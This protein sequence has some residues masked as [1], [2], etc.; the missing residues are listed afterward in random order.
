MA[1]T[2]GVNVIETDG[3]AAPSIQG[4]A[5]SVAAFVIRS[6]RGVPGAVRRISS[7]GQFRDLFGGVM[8]GAFGAFAVQG[9]LDNGGA[10][11]YVTRVVDDTA[12]AASTVT[13]GSELTGTAGYRGVDDPG[14]WGDDVEVAVQD[15][16]VVS[17]AYDLIVRY[18]GTVVETWEKLTLDPPVGGPTRDPEAVINDPITGSKYITVTVPGSVTTNPAETTGFTALA[19][20]AED[21]LSGSAL[22]AA[23]AAAFSRFDPHD[24]QL[25]G[26]PESTASAVVTAGLTYCE[27]RGDC[28]FIGAAP[29]GLD[30]DGARTYGQGFQGNKVYGALYYPW[31]QVLDPRGGRI[32]IPSTGH[33]MGV[34]ARIDQQRGVWKA[35]A[36]NEARVL[37]A[38][39]TE[40][41]LSD[42]DHTDLVKNGSVNAIRFIPGAGIVV[43]SSRTL[44]TNTLWLYVNVRLLFNFV[45]TSLKYGLRWVVQEPNTDELWQKVKVNTVN[46]F[47]MNLWR[48]GAFGP[49]AA[50]DVFTVKCDADNNPPSNI[51][52]GIFTLEVYL[53]PNRP[54]ETVVI[55]VGQQEGASS[56][57]EA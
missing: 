18:R 43:D 45:K 50:E 27:N 3:K 47:L 25:V 44:S 26:C 56:A 19:G 41:A 4:A 12:A 39:G 48:K 34:Y 15:N 16:S 22:E 54:A 33:V 7:P 11:A 24:V 29:P 52:Q 2:L 37:G 51:Q 13:L 38:L 1:L 55:V 14:E 32:T 53:Y 9:F 42:V 17:G 30:V 36:G 28:L 5:T 8:D 40:T 23:L 35:P 49:G 57:Q 21:S 20:G 6:E 46:P 31:I 10:T